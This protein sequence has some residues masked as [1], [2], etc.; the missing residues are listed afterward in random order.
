MVVSGFRCT[1]PGSVGQCDAGRS[2]GSRVNTA[3][4]AFPD[5]FDPVAHPET[6]GRA[7]GSPL[8]VAGDSRRLAPGPRPSQGARRSLFTRSRGTGDAATVRCAPA[9]GQSGSASHPKPLRCDARALR[10]GGELRPD[11]V[12]RDPAAAGRGVETAIGAGENAGRIADHLRD[13][14]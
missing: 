11:D 14:L 13:P 2:P 3:G 1:P 9:C 5:L 6:G 8:T 10:H 7:S 4:P 12:L